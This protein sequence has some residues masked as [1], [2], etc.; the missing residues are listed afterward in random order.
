[1]AGERAPGAKALA[2]NPENLGSI[3]VT[4]LVEGMV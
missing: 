3:P 4:Q 1:M 2:A